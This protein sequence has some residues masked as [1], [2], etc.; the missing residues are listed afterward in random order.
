MATLSLEDTMKFGTHIGEQ[1]E[2][3]IE[4]HPDYIRWMVE[5]EAIDLDEEAMQALDKRESRRH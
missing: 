3:L 4:D 5:E 1:I 2:D